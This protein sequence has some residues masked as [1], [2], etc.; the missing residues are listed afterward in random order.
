VGED[1]FPPTKTALAQ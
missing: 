1:G